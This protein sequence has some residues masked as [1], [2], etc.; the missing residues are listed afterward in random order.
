MF[1]SYVP[2]KAESQR[3]VY[4][5]DFFNLSEQGCPI[6]YTLMIMSFLMSIADIK[7]IGI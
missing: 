3:A 6:Y 2:V 5:A 4:I 7:L 1:H